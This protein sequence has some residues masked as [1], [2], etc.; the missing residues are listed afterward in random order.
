MIAIMHRVIKLLQNSKN[1]IASSCNER[2]NL[3]SILSLAFLLCANLYAE[4]SPDKEKA[5]S[6]DSYLEKIQR[7]YIPRLP[8]LMIPAIVVP[9]IK[10]G[11]LAGHLIVMAELKG[12][13]TEEYRKLQTDIVKVRDEIFCDLYLAMSRLWIG[14]EAPQARTLEKRIEKRINTFYK[15]SMVESARLHVMQLSLVQN[16]QAP[17]VS[18]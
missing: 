3:V 10:K 6:E 4:V 16:S 8:Y 18:L 15:S 11:A 2:G 5:S 7:R 14:P 12:V 9:V 1:V 17:I 13:G